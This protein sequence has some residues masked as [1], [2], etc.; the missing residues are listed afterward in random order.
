MVFLSHFISPTRHLPC[1]GGDFFWAFSSRLEVFQGI[2]IKWGNLTPRLIPGKSPRSCEA[3]CHPPFIFQQPSRTSRSV[4][5]LHFIPLLY[6]H[7]PV[8]FWFLW[9]GYNALSNGFQEINHQQAALPI[10]PTSGF[11]NSGHILPECSCELRSFDQIGF[12]VT[13]ARP[14]CVHQ[15][16]KCLPDFNYIVFLLSS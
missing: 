4:Y 5:Y 15:L 12:R 7:I 14:C 13:L 1:A 11:E 6:A 3:S 8:L 9:D 16:L 10:I 2:G